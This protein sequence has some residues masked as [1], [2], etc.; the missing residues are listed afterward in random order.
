MTRLDGTMPFSVSH[1]IASVPLRDIDA[2]APVWSVDGTQLAYV[3]LG[4]SPDTALEVAR[5]DGGGIEYTV[6]LTGHV[7]ADLRRSP[8]DERYLLV[9]PREGGGSDVY[10]FSVESDGPS[11]I[12]TGTTAADWSPEG[13]P[14]VVAE[15]A[16]RSVLVVQPGRE[17]R[18]VAQFSTTPI[19]VRWSPD[20]R[21]MAV[22]TAG[23]V[24]QGYGDA[25][26]VVDV[27]DGEITSLIDGEA[28]AL[29]PAWS[30]DGKR[31][32]FTRGPLVRRSGLPY[33]DLW[34]Y[35]V[36]SGNLDQLTA[37]QG[38]AGLGTW[39]P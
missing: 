33:G 30:S 28:W 10:T 24:R 16:S 11:L 32:L 20:S 21:L 27:A 19:D 14:I 4:Q 25:L 23:S 13:Q 6:S 7:A 39:S 3:T 2:A 8:V 31:L 22:V 26:H 1:P 18:P 38:F 9:G 12:M 15:R 35:D 17:V 5:A 29:W 34:V 37:Q 36:V